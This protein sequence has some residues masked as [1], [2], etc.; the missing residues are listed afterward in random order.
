MTTSFEIR[1][2]SANP[3][4]FPQISGL[5]RGVLNT[6]KICAKLGGSCGRSERALRLLLGMGATTHFISERLERLFG[7]DAGGRFL[8]AG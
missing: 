4:M 1:N 6:Q 2:I 8:F 3:H 5:I 7:S